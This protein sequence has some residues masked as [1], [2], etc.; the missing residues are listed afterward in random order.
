VK[1]AP[2]T[3]DFELDGQ[4]YRAHPGR[5]TSL[6]IPIAFGG[7]GVSAFGVPPPT[8]TAVSGPGFVGA[9]QLIP[10]CHGTHTECVGHLVDEP[11]SVDAVLRETP[12]PATLVS[13]ATEPAAGHPEAD[14]A[15]AAPDDRLVTAEALRRALGAASPFL[16]AV[17]IRTLPNRAEKLAARYDGA[18]PPPYLTAAAATLLAGSGCE[19][20]I[21]DLPSLDRMLDGGKLAAHRAF[22]GLPA[23]S[24]ARAEATR[25]HCTITELA[26]IADEVGDGRYLLD[27]QLAPLASDAAPSRPLLIPVEPRPRGVPA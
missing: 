3:L 10:H 7:D 21:V 14:P 2:L 23:G 20:V 17:V 13:V 4:R 24:R 15:I 1:G 25:G 27:L 19:H 12:I 5:A 18:R 16:R 9:L 11:V 22:F 26:F 8:A 6:A